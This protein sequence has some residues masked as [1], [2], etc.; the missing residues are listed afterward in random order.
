MSAAL[1][2]R[3]FPCAQWPEYQ[4][5]HAS[6]KGLLLRDQTGG[7]I[8]AKVVRPVPANETGG[9]ALRNIAASLPVSNLFSPIDFRSMSTRRGD[10]V[11]VCQRDALTAIRRLR[12]RTTTTVDDQS[13][14]R[15]LIIPNVAVID[16]KLTAHTSSPRLKNVARTFPAASSPGSCMNT[17]VPR[18]RLRCCARDRAAGRGTLR[19][20]RGAQS[21]VAL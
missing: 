16:M 3:P 20:C 2:T 7:N 13:K 18:M 14:C 4:L 8:D 17:P 6:T 11:L 1:T 5:Q 10:R 19:C 21:I 12:R 15:C 9:G